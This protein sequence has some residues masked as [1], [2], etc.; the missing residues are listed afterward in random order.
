MILTQGTRLAD[1]PAIVRGIADDAY[2]P[3]QGDGKTILLCRWSKRIQDDQ[4][5]GYAERWIPSAL[6]MPNRW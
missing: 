5:S 2:T 6:E 1:V 4:V 3:M